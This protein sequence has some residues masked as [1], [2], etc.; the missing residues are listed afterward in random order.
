[1]SP[2]PLASRRTTCDPLQTL[3]LW[4]RRAHKAGVPEPD[5]MT[6]ATAARGGRPSARVV[7]LRGVD[8]RGLVFFTNYRSCKGRELVANPRAAL[9]FYWGPIARQVRVEGRVR[10]L[11]AAESDLY[12]DSRPRGARLAAWA[13]EQSTIIPSREHLL[14]RYRD[15]QRRFRDRRVPRPPHWGGFR[16]E[17]EAIEFWRSRPHRLHDRLRFERRPKGW[18]VVRLAP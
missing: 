9:V 2:N 1:M 16:L 5:A 13:S 7:L 10:R 12:F 4:L 3:V 17:P 18:R 14:R 15:V 11:A 8:Q 6:L